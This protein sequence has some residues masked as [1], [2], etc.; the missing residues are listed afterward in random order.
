MFISFVWLT[1]SVVYMKYKKTNK[2]EMYKQ[3]QVLIYLHVYAF[4]VNFKK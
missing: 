3:K 4:E 2:V 1:K